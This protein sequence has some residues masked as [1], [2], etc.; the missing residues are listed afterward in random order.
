MTLEKIKRLAGKDEAV[1]KSLSFG[2]LRACTE[3]QLFHLLENHLYEKP[4]FLW[5]FRC[6]VEQPHKRFADR[7][8]VRLL[9]KLEHQA[10][11]RKR[12]TLGFCLDRLID[13]CSPDTR[14]T[15][16]KTF[17]NS[18]KRYLRKYAYKKDLSSM[19][20]EVWETTY[21]RL[22]EFPDEAPYFL[23]AVGR[24]YP[25]AFI[26]DNF[27]RLITFEQIDQYQISKLFIRK[28]Q[29]SP[30]DWKWLKDNFPDSVLYIAAKR[31]H[32]LTDEECARFAGSL[33][34]SWFKQ[35]S[36]TYAWSEETHAWS[37]VASPDGLKLWCLAK[38]GKWEIIRRLLNTSAAGK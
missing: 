26:E 25:D 4:I 21:K 17:L 28:A 20:P 24:S 1:N 18:G 33:Y 13:K 11:Y 2:F 30:D 31:D 29:L 23:Q 9:S 38:M 22:K 14:T 5:V 10:D 8:A 32:V 16:I 15:V 12:Q 6:Y 34:K 35:N 27:Y 19:P 36:E 3:D 37:E 7:L